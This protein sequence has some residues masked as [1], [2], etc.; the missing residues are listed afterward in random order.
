[1]PPAVD[2]HDAGRVRRAFFVTRARSAAPPQTVFALLADAPAW[3][4]WAGPFV[5]RA[6]W[7]P[8]TPA[9][10]GAVRR[11]GFGRLGVREQV[12][13][14]E[15]PHAFSYVLLTGV[16]WHGYR[17][18]VRLTEDEHGGTRVEWAGQLSSPLP[19]LPRLLLPAFRLLVE[20]FTRRLVVRAERS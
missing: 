7:E 20:Q 15:P 1:M 5:P 11:L 18:D 3:Q 19:G 8:G 9:G 2:L 10:V 17:A 14:H 16:R 4:E 12:V 6:Q 13:L